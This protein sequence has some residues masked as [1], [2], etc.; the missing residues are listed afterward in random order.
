MKKIGFIFTSLTLL[1]LVAGCTKKDKIPGYLKIHNFDLV[2]NPNLGGTEGELTYKITDVW[3]YIDGKALGVFQLPAEIPILEEGEHELTLIPGINNNGISATKE[4]YVLL[5]NF[6]Q[7]ITLTPYETTEV[8]PYTFYKTGLEFIIEDFEG[9][10]NTF[11]EFD[12]SPA[13]MSN[14]TNGAVYGN[15]CGRVVLNETDSVW[16]AKTNWSA[17]LPKGREVYLEIDYAIAAGVLVGTEAGNSTGTNQSPYIELRKSEA[18]N[19]PWKKIY[20]DLEENVS[21]EINATFYNIVLT[22]I[23]PE[24]EDEA[25]VLLDNVKLVYFP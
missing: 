7:T 9:P 10:T 3:V 23:L 1:L 24:G 6:E 4:R 17:N 5:E 15:Y 19:I 14:S 2:A 21:Y 20:I 25:V 18:T 8:N 12:I 13:S 11:Q 22:S 16:N